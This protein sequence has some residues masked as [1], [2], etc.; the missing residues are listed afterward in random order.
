MLVQVIDYLSNK[1]FENK[2]S[3][4]NLMTELAQFVE[5]YDVHPI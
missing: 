5:L 2:S 3:E 1:L 4:V